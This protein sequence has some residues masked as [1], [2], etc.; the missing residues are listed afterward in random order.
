MMK[1]APYKRYAGKRRSHRKWMWVALSS[2]AALIIVVVGV[3]LGYYLWFNAKVAAANDRVPDDVWSI[4]AEEDEVLGAAPEAPGAEN[5]LLVG[6]DSRSGVTEGS[7]SD[8]I[9]LVHT[10]PAN[11][12]M[13][14][15]SL[16]RDLH[17]EVEGHGSRKLNYSYAVGGPGLL[18][19]TVQ[20]VTGIDIDHYMEID[21]KAFSDMTDK[22][23]GVYLE[24][25]RQY[26]QLKT[27]EEERIRL[28]PGY[29]LLNGT[30]ALT[31]V[32]FRYDLNADFGRMARQQRYLNA[33]RQQAMG[34]DLGT[35]FT[36][37]VGSFMDNATTDIGTNAFMKLALW[38][39]KLDGQ[40]SKQVVLRGVN[41]MSGGVTFVFCT[42]EQINAAVKSVLALPETEVAAT[43]ATTTT[44][45]VV[46]TTTTAKAGS[47]GT[48]VKAGSTATTAKP[49]STATTAKTASTATT[50]AASTPATPGSIPNATVWKGVAKVVPFA[51][52]APGYVPRDYRIAPRSGTYAYVYDIKVGDVG[53]PT[54]VMLYH[55]TG[56][57]SSGKVKLQEEYINVTETTWLDAPAASPGKEVTYNGTVFTVVSS[58]D[59]VE[60]IWW[61]SD[62]I[63]YWVSNSLDR[64]ASTAE[65]L[66]MAESMVRIP[67][68]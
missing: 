37:L 14:M 4:L 43:G 54:L 30:Q 5:I 55:N 23:G 26:T 52:Q 7:R 2:V 6:S 18:I 47:T 63:L 45:K 31:Y 3:A 33:V 64:V 68:Q 35:K 49:G 40:R 60:R 29:Q 27:V 17:V 19:K 39:I 53:K 12:Y 61:R 9:M 66:K 13:S 8:V 67:K 44:A 24:V 65:L 15:L 21:F 48:T 38:C 57:G 42:E 32:R 62:G 36:G 46:S 11:N 56:R 25:D 50:L 58:A 20:Q 1:R 22:L 51:V 10:D 34:W 41:K 59:K 28:D 16:P